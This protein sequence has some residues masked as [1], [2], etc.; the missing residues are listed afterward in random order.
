ML[1]LPFKSP[2]SSTSGLLATAIRRLPR[3]DIVITEYNMY[4]VQTSAGILEQSMGARLQGGIG[5]SY[6]GLPGYI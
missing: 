6:K 5:L 3:Q 2:L 4:T 1:P